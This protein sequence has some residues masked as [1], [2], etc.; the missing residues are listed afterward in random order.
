MFKFT[1]VFLLCANL[2]CARNTQVGVN[3]KV[4]GDQSVGGVHLFE[5]HTPTGGMGVGVKIVIISLIIGAIFY[6]CINKKVK[7]CKRA[8]LPYSVAANNVS[9]LSRVAVSDL[10]PVHPQPPIEPRLTRPRRL[11]DP[12]LF[13][14]STLP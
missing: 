13:S 9:Q 6:W 8:M 14:R 7:Q 12:E 4:E 3:N 1:V 11:S 5:L 2:C 10:A